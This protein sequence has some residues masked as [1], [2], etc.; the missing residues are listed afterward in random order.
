[1]KV[2]STYLFS[3]LYSLAA[4]SLLCLAWYAQSIYMTVTLGWTGLSISLVALAYIFKA[5]QIFRK[6]SDGSIPTYIKWLYIP[7]LGGAQLYNAW[8]RKTDKVPPMQKIE[9]QL[10]LACRLFPS[11]IEQLK[12]QGISAI[13]DVTAEF[14]GLDISADP[15]TFSYL[16]LPVLD[17]QSPNQDQIRHGCNW[18]QTQLDNGQSVVVH[19]A[20]G[21]GRSFMLVLAYLLFSKRHSQLD[22]AIQAVQQIRHTAGL[23]RTQFKKLAKIIAQH[24]PKDSPQR[25][26]LIINPVSGGGKWAQHKNEIVQRLTK[27]Y[28]LKIF[29]TTGDISATEMTEKAIQDG[30]SLIIGCGGDGTVNEVASCLRHTDIELGIIPLGTTNA[31]SHVLHGTASKVLPI[32]NSCDVLL[33]KYVKVIDTAVCNDELVLLMVSIGM[34]QKMISSASRDEKNKSGQMAYIKGLWQAISEHESKQYKLS[35]DNEQASIEATNIAIAN[36]APFSTILAQ[37]QGEPDPT[38]GFLDVTVLTKQD[39]TASTLNNMANL[40]LSNL[41]ENTPNSSMWFKRAQAVEISSLNAIQYAVDGETRQATHLTIK[42]EP[43]SL[44][45]I[46]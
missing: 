32:Q 38:D 40:A 44:Q 5:P 3:L 2:T 29:V 8:A 35:I 21:R 42:C 34:G 43:K 30:Y 27:R 13:L 1:M 19:C 33:D 36:A 17:H 10:F 11:D 39:N 4:L 20:L 14:D 25:A 15:Q 31:L 23:N 41:I 12:Q 18:I 24:S 28:L 7:F 16:N 37:G 9:P 45:V 26:A 22:T 6:S 46:A